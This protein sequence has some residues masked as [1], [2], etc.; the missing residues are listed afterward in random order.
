MPFSATNTVPKIDA[1]VT[2][3]LAGLLLLKAGE[4]NTCEVGVHR[5]SAF[6]A[7]QVMLVVNQPG[8]PLELIRLITGPLTAPVS[9]D[10]VPAPESGFQLF[11]HEPFGRENE[12]SHQFDYRWAINMRKLN[13]KADFTENARPGVTLNAG[14]LYSSKLTSPGLDPELIN[15]P[16][17]PPQPSSGPQQAGS[18]PKKLHKFAA[19][20]AVA[21]EVPAGSN[22]VIGWQESKEQKILNL[23]RG[24]DDPGTT[25]TISLMND[26]PSRGITVPHDELGLYYDVLEEDGEPIPLAKQFRFKTR[27][28]ATD[29]IPCMPVTVGPP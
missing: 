15:P 1:T 9:I 28:D 21:I 22:L 25:Y 29:A 11:A 2:V 14:I 18:A 5:L 8:K 10:L 24:T 27:E 26:P 20:L 16:P 7:F 6:H 19:D 23:P 17:A 13:P 3:K 12:R 4:G